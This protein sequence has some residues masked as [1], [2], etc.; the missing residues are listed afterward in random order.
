MY[1]GARIIQVGPSS[2]CS[3]IV[4]VG[5]ARVLRA[6][7]RRTATRTAQ[8]KARRE[9]VLLFQGSEI[10]SETI[11]MTETTTTEEDFQITENYSDRIRETSAG[12]VDA[13]E[14]LDSKMIDEELVVI[15]YKRL[16]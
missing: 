1:E 8:V 6:S 7:M 15:L 5:A 11:I 2:E 10:E 9:V 13:M 12:F 3:F 4:A 14:P 16:P